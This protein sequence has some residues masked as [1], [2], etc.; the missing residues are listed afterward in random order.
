MQPKFPRLLARL[1]ASLRIVTYLFVVVL[2]YS[3]CLSRAIFREVPK[4]I[5]DDLTAE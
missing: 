1:I 4:F 2:A 5:F 3:A